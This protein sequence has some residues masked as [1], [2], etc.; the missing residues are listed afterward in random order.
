LKQ[1]FNISIEKASEN[2]QPVLLIELGEKH[3]DYAIINKT[4]GEVAQLAYYSATE[5][6]EE[7]IL[8]AIIET[9]ADLNG[10]FYEVIV[11]YY[12]PQA[13]LVPVKYY[14]YE[15]AANILKQ[16]NGIAERSVMVS[17]PVTEWQINTVYNVPVPAY[18]LIKKQYPNHKSCHQYSLGIKN[19]IVTGSDGEIWLNIHSESFSVL[20]KK[21][22]ALLLA[23]MYEYATPEDIIYRIL[24]VCDQFSLSQQQVVIH[25]YGLIEK[26][27][28]LYRELYKYF[29]KL[30]FQE[31][32]NVKFPES[33]KE[34]PSHFFTSL[35]NLASCV[36]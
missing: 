23:Q 29:V 5:E 10:T 4:S 6:N 13:V 33:F 35:F 20:V 36:S 24:K 31:S 18:D 32:G 21:E 12:Y 15:E 16:M 11:G 2:T 27:S 14:N 25:L 7:N 19:C 17:E 9:N 1:L 3:C 28:A 30:S 34:H 22:S 26:Q 8:Q